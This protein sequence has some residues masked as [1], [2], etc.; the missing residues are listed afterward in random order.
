MADITSFVRLSPKEAVL[1]N[2]RVVEHREPLAGAKVAIGAGVFVLMYY[3]TK[4]AIKLLMFLFAIMTD[5]HIYQLYEEVAP[6]RGLLLII[7]I[8]VPAL[9]V[10]YPLLLKPRTEGQLVLTN[11]RLLYVSQGRAP[12]LRRN[13]V[14]VTAVNLADVLGV[15]S[16]YT[17]NLLGRKKLHLLIHTRFRDGLSLETE[18]SA[19]RLGRLPLVGDPFYRDTLTTDAVAM[20]PQLFSHIQQRAGAAIGSTGSY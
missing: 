20:L 8:G 16:V 5:G 15:H 14:N 19:S 11:W 6:F 3:A 17:E 2:W 9:W 18:E 13:V 10:A 7:E 4:Y 1:D 12:A